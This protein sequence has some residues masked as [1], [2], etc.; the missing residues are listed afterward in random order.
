MFQDNLKAIRKEKGFT[1]E[2]LAIELHVVRQTVSKWE[3]GLSV[4]DAEMLQKLSEVLE[5]PVA[6][7]LGAELP[8][9]EAQRNE[10]AEQLAKINEQLAIKNRRSRRVLKTVIIILAVLILL[11]VVLL[12]LLRFTRNS[13]VSTEEAQPAGTVS[14]VCELNGKEYPCELEYDANYR[15]LSLMEDFYISDHL[16]ISQYTDAN[17]YAAHLF[18]WFTERGG[19]VRITSASGE[20]LAEQPNG[21]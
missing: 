5:T 3:K 21:D 15:I 13:I 12:P 11:P 4:P 16:D 17:E 6:R 20:P 9:E 7:L 14:I 18:D 1:Q 2:S 10:I 19:T 8:T